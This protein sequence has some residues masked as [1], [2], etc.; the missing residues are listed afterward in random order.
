M[1]QEELF[2]SGPPAR[3]QNPN[4]LH[5]GFCELCGSSDEVKTCSYCQHEFCDECG[6][7]KKRL[8]ERCQDFFGARGR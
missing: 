7:M 5:I 6:S 3:I 4:S 2:D 8:C 1:T